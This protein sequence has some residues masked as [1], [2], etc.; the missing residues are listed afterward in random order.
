MLILW[1]LHGSKNGIFRDFQSGLKK[2]G[3]TRFSKGK[4]LYKERENSVLGRKITPM[5]NLF[6]DEIGGIFGI[7][8]DHPSLGKR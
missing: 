7:F 1:G 2:R 6:L 4:V 3:N 8:R 5:K